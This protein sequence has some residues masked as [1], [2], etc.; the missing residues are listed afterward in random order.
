MLIAF[1]IVLIPVTAVSAQKVTPGST[2]KVLKQ[3][4]D[5]LDKTYTCTKSGKK[6]VWNKGVAVKKPTLT[7]T[8]TPT[9]T[10]IQISI[11][12]LDLKGVLPR[13]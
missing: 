12:N 13:D 6:L 3:K 10:P 2:C 8:P 9:P 5:Y 11:D 1:A 4:V 7:P